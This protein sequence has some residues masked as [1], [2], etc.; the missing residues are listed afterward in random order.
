MDPQR[1]REAEVAGMCQE[2]N[3][4]GAAV[5]RAV[6]V[7]PAGPRVI[8]LDPLVPFGCEELHVLRRPRAGRANCH[9]AVVIFGQFQRAVAGTREAGVDVHQPIARLEADVPE[10]DIPR[11]NEGD[12]ATGGLADFGFVAGREIDVLVLGL[13]LAIDGAALGGFEGLEADTALAAGQI[14]EIDIPILERGLG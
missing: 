9:A 4:G 10:A 8:A 5:D 13:N 6:N 3:S 11:L 7:A 14:P 12:L 1:L 2:G